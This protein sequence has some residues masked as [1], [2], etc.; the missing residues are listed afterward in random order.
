MDR[1]AAGP[2]RRG[3][4]GA[5][6]GGAG[7]LL[8]GGAERVRGP[9]RP[10]G[11]SAAVVA[12]RVVLP[13][14]PGRIVAEN[15]LGGSGGWQLGERTSGDLDGR[16]KAYAADLAVPSGGM[17]RLRVSSEMPYSVELYRLGDYGGM[18]GRLMA[19]ADGLAAIRQAQPVLDRDAGTVTC[20]WQDSWETAIPAEW[21]SGL[22]TA[23]LA[24]SDGVRTATP[25][26]VTELDREADY[27]VV[28][29]AT[30][31]QA[32]NEYPVDGLTGRS[33]YY[34][35]DPDTRRS[36][37]RFKARVVSFDRPYAGAGLP[38]LFD[39]DHAF[40]RWAE[41]R[42]Y[43]VA[44]ATSLDLHA[45]RV[46]P[47]RYKALVFPG[48]DEYWSQE[49]RTHAEAA[50]RAGVGLAFLTANNMYWHVRMLPAP[51]GTPHRLMRCNKD[52]SS[53]RDRAAPGP[54]VKW[55]DLH[56]PE[57]E[58]LGVQYAS[59]VKGEQPLIVREAAHWFWAGSG[60]RD[61]DALPGMVW[62]EADRRFDDA[63]RPR[64]EQTFLAASPYR[65]SRGGG[66]RQQSGLYRAA[67]G[68]L[69][70]TAGTFRWPQALGD[71]RHADPRIAR[72]T[73]N[74]FRAFTAR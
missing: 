69:V 7:M 38:Q 15:S 6:V 30:T 36:D 54:T 19:R 40:V 28:L 47:L 22:Y 2:S 1:E 39:L 74:L 25:F 72:A 41:R 45:G 29:P 43:D 71:P 46:D 24:D 55:R 64:A 20:A 35:Q 8:V 61:G 37:A 3:L 32:Y 9:V 56:R 51:D 52:A 44:Y 73:E 66:Q 27:L 63:A 16:I 42:G 12:P 17:L 23:V 13:A 53:S 70:F 50:S 14:M 5:V 49:M 57:Q 48:H 59:V 33:L 18:G 60:V 4:L 58:L 34:G 21:P 67:S 65:D 26:V 31:Y 10:V 11:E 68:G 62:G